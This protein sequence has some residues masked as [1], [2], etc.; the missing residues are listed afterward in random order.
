MLC[1]LQLCCTFI[2]VVQ[3]CDALHVFYV[4]CNVFSPGLLLTLKKSLVCPPYAFLSLLSPSPHHLIIDIYKSLFR[5][6]HYASL[7]ISLSPLCSYCFLIPTA[8]LLSRLTSIHFFHVF[9]A[10]CFPSIRLLCMSAPFFIPEL[11]VLMTHT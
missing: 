7:P 6:S 4:S 2:L 3:C 9:L 10:T 11:E 5:L 1:S 8:L